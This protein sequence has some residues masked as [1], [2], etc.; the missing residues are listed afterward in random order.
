LPLPLPGLP[1]WRQ[2]NPLP[3]IVYAPQHVALG[4]PKCITTD[5]CAACLNNTCPNQSFVLAG[6]VPE[7]KLN[8]I[9][10]SKFVIDRV[11]IIFDS[12]FC[13][14]D[15]L[16][17]LVILETLSNQFDNLPLFFGRDSASVT[18]RPQYVYLRR[19]N[20]A[21]AIVGQVRTRLL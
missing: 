2:R 21:K 19:L 16:R 11:N 15:F 14:S 1:F 18:L 7:G 17:D 12:V 4:G 3:E 20:G 9:P 13:G 5:E 10:K 8:S 6:F